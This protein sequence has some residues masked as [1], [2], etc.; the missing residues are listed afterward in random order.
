MG[1]LRSSEYMPYA[2]AHRGTE[3]VNHDD[4]PAGTDNKRRLYVT[5]KEDGHVVAYCYNCGYSGA[6]SGTS[7]PSLFVDQARSLK[8]HTVD[9]PQTSRLRQT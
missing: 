4:C 9:D 2:T 7:K 3:R 8:L 1:R 5:R 6:T